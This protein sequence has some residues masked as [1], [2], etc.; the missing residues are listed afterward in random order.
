MLPEVPDR[1]LLE[2]GRTGGG[3][4]ALAFLA[5]D[6]DTRRLLLLRAVLDA[7]AGADPALCPADAGRRL[8]EDWALLEAADATAAADEPAGDTSVTKGPTGSPARVR[9]LAPLVGAWA[10]RCLRG[11]GT[12]PAR[13]GAPQRAREFRRDLDH[14]SALAAA[15]AARAGLSFA[16]RLTA[17]DGLLVLPSL[18]ALRT[19]ETG[20]TSVE[21]VHRGGRLTM[22]RRGAADVVVHVERGTGAWSGAASW[23]PAYALPGLTT[24]APPTPL[25]DLD[26]YRWVQDGVHH[27][28]LSGPAS[29]D[30]AERKR[31]LHSWSGTAVELRLGGE[32]RL[33]EA[34]RLLRCLVPLAAP[35][36]SEPGDCTGTCSGTR[37]EAFGAVLSSAPHAPTVLAATL[38]HE[39]QHTKLVA[40]SEAV[41]LHRA[42][43]RKR[44]FAPWRTDPRPYDGLLQGTYSH[45]ALA[46]FFQQRA[47]TLTRPADRE[48]AWAEHARC[49]EQV[50]AAL[51]ALVGSPDL[52]VPGRRFVDQMVAVYERLDEH[53]APRGHAVRAQAYV[54]AARGLFSAR[55]TPPTG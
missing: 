36:G 50:G 40:L 9:L 6:Q 35:P 25:D 49:R 14:F 27:L 28:G 43:G 53:P 20:D 33:L 45:L 22:R 42:D 11:L 21:V 4:E 32:Q 2:L 48:A 3:P 52:T 23:T 10:Q 44:Y 8:L 15:A 24:G 1:I 29:L 18:G 38:V 26:P 19:A 5:R 31:W 51:P 30:D 16:V 37:R 47:L 13:P 54:A 34:V 12:D 17:R 46:D 7:V 41:T 39:L 55:R